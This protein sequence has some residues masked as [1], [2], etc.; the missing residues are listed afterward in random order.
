MKGDDDIKKVTIKALGI[1]QSKKYQAD[2][3]IYNRNNNMVFRGKT[4]NGILKLSL[5]ENEV[6][7]LEATLLNEKTCIVFISKDSLIEFRLKNNMINNSNSRN[8]IFLL[9][10]YYYSLPIE[11]GEII[12]WQK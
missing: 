1:G 2:I 10:D 9:S 12:L 4:N 3:A 6:Y 5:Q 8:V 11:K 7:R